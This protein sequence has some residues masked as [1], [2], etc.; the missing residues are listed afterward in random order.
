MRSASTI[1]PFR[2]A[3]RST[4]TLHQ[5]VP[6][7]R[8]RPSSRPPPRRHVLG[9]RSAVTATT[10][11]WPDAIERIVSSPSAGAW[12]TST[13][14]ASISSAPSRACLSSTTRTGGSDH[15]AH[16]AAPVLHEPP[17]RAAPGRSRY[18]QSVTNRSRWRL[19][20]ERRRQDRPSGDRHAGPHVE[21]RARHRHRRRQH[22]H[23]RHR[24]RRRQRRHGRH[25]HRRRQHR[26]GRHRPAAGGYPVPHVGTRPLRRRAGGRILASPRE[27]GWAMR[28]SLG[29]ASGRTTRWC[30]PRFVTAPLHRGPTPSDF[31]ASAATRKEPQ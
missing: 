31:P 26:H 7:S 2:T 18:Q 20:D 3:P 27:G 9:C 1:A 16:T 6:G 13:P 24:H 15:P 11:R 30:G 23:G 28:A 4:A 21:R 5:M 10:G 29:A 17:R 8:N 25:R 19:D 12:T 22:R 14:S